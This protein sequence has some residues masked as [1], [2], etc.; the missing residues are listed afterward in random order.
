[1]S[2]VVWCD[3]GG[4]LMSANDPDREFFTAQGNAYGQD[5]KQKR[6]DTCA[7]HRLPVVEF[8]ELPGVADL[9]RRVAALEAPPE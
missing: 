7:K 2:D 4:H 9:Q 1:M 8:P 6:I 5:Q 3:Y